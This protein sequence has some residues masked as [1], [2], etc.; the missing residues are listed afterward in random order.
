MVPN[1]PTSVP[2]D[3]PPHWRDDLAG[4]AWTT[5]TIGRSS[6]TVFRLQADK[7]PSF[8]VKIEPADASGE[9]LAEAARL[10]WLAASGI[11]CPQV[12]NTSSDGQRNWLLTRALP[13]RDLASSPHLAAEQIVTI[14]ADALRDL[15]RLDPSPCP[16]DQR[17]DSRIAAAEAR[18]RAGLVDESDFDDERLGQPAHAVFADLLRRRPAQEDLVVTHGDACLPNLMADGERFSGFVDCAR[19][20]VADRHQDLA[21]ASWSIRYNLGQAWIAPFLQRYGLR[22]DPELLDF[23]RLLDDFF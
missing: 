18:M 22:A 6:A 14:A 4:Y 7:R 21:L 1:A 20:G 13:G 11:A 9:L 5:Q 19:L 10:R 8:F 23:Y 2:S 15:H 16:F 12:E 17:L 3:M